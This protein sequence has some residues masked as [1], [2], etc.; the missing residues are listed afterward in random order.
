MFKI[1]YL[2]FIY[3]F[4]LC[5]SLNQLIPYLT[6]HLLK[7][8]NCWNAAVG[9]DAMQRQSME[10]ILATVL[11]A[12]TSSLL[13]LSR[14][15]S[16]TLLQ[17]F[18]V[19]SVS[20]IVQCKDGDWESQ[21]PCHTANMCMVGDQNSTSPLKPMWLER[22]WLWLLCSSALQIPVTPKGIKSGSVGEG[23]LSPSVSLH[24]WN[25]MRIHGI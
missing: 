25:E 23:C 12:L 22:L 9:N 3:L 1:V 11:L 7:Q 16:S 13:D 17:L 15:D 10:N 24:L 19:D 2:L 20:F 14:C 6:G 18:R 8:I 21:L 4:D 5:F